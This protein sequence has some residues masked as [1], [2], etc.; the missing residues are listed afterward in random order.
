MHNLIWDFCS[1]D[2][3]FAQELVSSS[4]PASFRFEVTLDTLAF[5]YILPT[6]G[7][8]R[9]FNPLETCAARRT[10]KKAEG[11]RLLLSSRLVDGHLSWVYLFQE[12]SLVPCLWSGGHEHRAVMKFTN[13]VFA[14]SQQLVL[15]NWRN[16]T[17]WIPSCQQE[18]WF[19]SKNLFIRVFQAFFRIKTLK[20]DF[21]D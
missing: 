12:I 1:S 2:Q 19:F 9:D 14:N 13:Q 3:R 6:P 5:G 20:S 10:T 16:N 21:T 4:Y 8:I 7:Q 15:S 18:I 11:E 17:L